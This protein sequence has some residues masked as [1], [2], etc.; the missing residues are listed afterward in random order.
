MQ[1]A[2]P[3]EELLAHRTWL[4]ALARSLVADADEAREL[5]QETWLA[6]LLHPPSDRRNLRGWLARVAVHG[7]RRRWR[8]RRFAGALDEGMV[9]DRGATPAELAA[10]VEVARGLAA[11]VLALDEPF[12]TTVLLRY[13]H[14][15]DAS[16]IARREKVAAGT[17]RWRLKRALD[18]LRARLQRE[19]GSIRAWSL[20]LAPLARLP[21]RSALLVLAAL[22]WLPAAVPVA[23]AAALVV[24]GT[25]L[26]RASAPRLDEP[27]AVAELV[28][29]TTEA[30]PIVE[31]SQPVLVASAAE[32]FA[33][34]TRHALEAPADASAASTSAPVAWLDG[35]VTDEA[36]RPIAGASV[37][38]PWVG[39]ETSTDAEGHFALAFG[40]SALEEFGDL[41]RDGGA[42][43]AH[44]EVSAEWRV[45]REHA[46]W[47]TAGERTGIG[48]LV[49]DP[50]G[51]IAGR[52]EVPVGDRRVKPVVG[53]GAG[54]SS[55]G[56]EKDGT[57]LLTG[58]PP[59]RRTVEAECITTEVSDSAEVDVEAGR[60]T[61]GV[62]LRLFPPPPPPAVTGVVLREDGSPAARVRLGVRG[63]DGARPPSA[64]GSERVTDDDGRFTLQASL[65]PGPIVVWAVD[66]PRPLDFPSF[67]YA[68]PAVHA[69]PGDDVTL[70]LPDRTLVRLMLVS[71]AGRPL[72]D[73][74]VQA[75]NAF[76]EHL[77][78]HFPRL[79][80]GT[81]IDVPA[82]P[83]DR[84]LV[85]RAV[86][87]HDV[88][89]KTLAMPSTE[90]PT[91]VLRSQP[92]V[93]GR[94]ID[95]EGRAIAGADVLL[96]ETGQNGDV[97]G[98]AVRSHL[99]TRFVT[100]EREVTDAEGRFAVPLPESVERGYVQVRASGFAPAEAGPWR[101]RRRDGDVDV[102][103][104]RVVRGGA[105]EGR[106]LDAA[107]SPK[108]GAVVVASRGDGLPATKRTDEQGRFAFERLTPGDWFVAEHDREILWPNEYRGGRWYPAPQFNTS[109]VD[110]GTSR[111]DITGTTVQPAT[112][113]ITLLVDD[114][115]PT[116]W[117]AALEL[118][119]WDDERWTDFDEHGRA[120]FD[121]AGLRG[122]AELFVQSPDGV[123]IGRHVE[124]PDDAL[125]FPL[126][127]RLGELVVEGAIAPDGEHPQFGAIA[128]LGEWIA[129]AALVPAEGETSATLR[130]P[131]GRWKVVSADDRADEPDDLRALVQGDVIAGLRTVLRVR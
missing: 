82:P 42:V 15:L 100:D 57:F 107:G 71:D 23:A 60:V 17:I 25:A 77:V 26:L 114:V 101:A 65:P 11:H 125:S 32:N 85:F 43:L 124:L 14:G 12:R 91:V 59:G 119:Q 35:R 24:G 30:G 121:V 117:T 89:W 38:A 39:A 18:E 27:R 5:E 109:V 102:G 40:E 49:L 28:D 93:V 66:C 62:V 76:G 10:E 45:T 81:A 64:T 4:A 80:S 115:V 120:E 74:H 94:A 67:E 87:H 68:G 131:A 54:N 92:H 105:I 21:S 19:H 52:I 41:R 75:C 106:V 129:A 116:G 95:A 31:A 70:H 69:Q 99:V 98:I 51:A 44:F 61:S 113:A 58:V 103:D 7:A 86:G 118:P 108:V 1:P 34:P 130:V 126:V 55:G 83:A 88:E 47:I 50:A 36:D 22:G 123:R 63:V 90:P 122:V 3:I 29:A 78:A 96:F 97:H 104:V 9:P 72:R 20:H 112:V 16:E 84:V 2:V 6:A 8:R 33:E 79:A 48:S 37:S 127:V 56:I 111:F 46:T 110:G 53:F 128:T 73:V 13:W